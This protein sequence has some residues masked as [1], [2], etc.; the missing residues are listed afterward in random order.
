[1][2]DLKNRLLRWFSE[3]MHVKSLARTEEK[4]VQG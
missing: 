4:E 1:M 2:K 3:M